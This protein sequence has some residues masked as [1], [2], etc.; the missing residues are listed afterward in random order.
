VSVTL[1]SLWTDVRRRLEAAGV[2][3]PVI[4]ARMLVEAGAGV[5][6]LDIVTDPRRAMGDD[7]VAAVEALALRRIA[8]EPI[9]HI[10]GR[11]GFWKLDLAVSRD[12][13]TPRPE[14]EFL[15]EAAL[16]FLAPDRAARVLDLGVG[17]GAILLAVLSERPQAIGVGVD[18]SA[19]ALPV[20]RANADALGLSARAQ[21]RTGDW[22]AGLDRGFDLIVSNPPYIASGEIAD[23]AP[24][25]S[26]YEP[27]LALDG[28]ADGLDAYRALLPHISALLAPSGRFALEVGH[29]QA[30]AVWA[31][32]EQAGLAPIDIR[33]DLAGIN[34]VVTGQARGQI[35]G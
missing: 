1:V 13:L 35:L 17:S 2:D 11:K 21:L 25:V 23:L 26:R 10:L 24:E 30:Q 6:R 5:S 8:R 18:A 15:V 7:Q 4:D 27:H 14:T 19:A 12:V 16:E 33:A 29:G 28:G 32:A 9:S 34:R 22:G 3:T 31:L 20:A